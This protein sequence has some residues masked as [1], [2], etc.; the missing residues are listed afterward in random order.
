MAF[1]PTTRPTSALICLAFATVT[2][3]I[4]I[5]LHRAGFEDL[6]MTHFLQVVRHMSG[7]GDRPAELARL[8]GVTPQAI[9]QTLTELEDLGYVRREPDPEDRRSLR[10]F[11][12]DRGLRAGRALEEHYAE[13][14][15]RWAERVGGDTV[16]A[17]RLLLSSVVT[18]DRSTPS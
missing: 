14:E 10:I 3:E 4:L 15:R 2:E 16:E 13:T 5:S 8:A 7:A 18:P 11:W 6:R 1:D 17:A 12:A 9:G